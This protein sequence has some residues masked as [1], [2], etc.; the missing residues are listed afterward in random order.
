MLSLILYAMSSAVI[1]M[2]QE[3]DNRMVEPCFGFF[4]Y[5][6]NKIRLGRVGR[7]GWMKKSAPDGTTAGV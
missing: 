5:A 4:G 6:V 2:N 1:G 7:V 3:Y